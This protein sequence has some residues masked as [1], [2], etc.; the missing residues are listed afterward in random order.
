M[1]QFDH[2]LAKQENPVKIPLTRHLVEV[3]K[4]AE[5][6][7][8]HLE[9][10]PEIAYKGAIL[11]DIGKTSPIYQA[12]LKRDFRR[13]VNT[14]IFRHEIAS[15][16]F[17]SLVAEEIKPMVIDMIV[18]HHK[19][20][21]KD[22]RQL[23]ILDLEGEL[24]NNFELHAEGFDLWSKDA[25]GILEIFGFEKQVITID[26]AR[27]NYEFAVE[28]CSKPRLGCSLWKGLLTGSDYFA[29]GVSD[30]LDNNI[31]AIFRKPDLSF[32]NRINALYPLSKISTTNDKPHTLVTAPTGAGKTD[33]LIRRCKG[34]VFY[35]LPFQASI[36]AMYERIKEDLRETGADIR[37][38]HASSTLTLGKGKLEETILQKHIGASVKV[39]TPHQIASIVFGTKGYEAM[40]ADLKG[41]DIILDEIH[42]YSDITQAI[43]LK[44][45]E[46]LN[47]LNC[48][49]HIGTATMSTVLY[50]KILQIL[51]DTERVYEVKLQ[52]ETLDT[53]DRHIVHKTTS[54]DELYSVIEDAIAN[55]Q[56]IL[57]VCNQVKRAQT[58]FKELSGK[59]C[60]IDKMLI[61]SRFKRLDRNRLE[62]ELKNVYN[63]STKACF[64]VS[65][66]VVEVSLDISFDL[67]IT[68]CAPL[69]ALIQR[70]GRINRKR[71]EQTIGKYKPVYVMQPPEEKGD[72]LPYSLD[73]LKRSYEA[74]QDGKLNKERDLQ[75][76]LDI[77][78][79]EINF[80]DIDMNSVFN[81]GKWKIKELCHNPKSALLEILDIDSISCV[82]ESDKDD[83]I[84]GKYIERSK[85]EIPVSYHS[86]AHNGLEQ[87]QDRPKPFIIPDKAYNSELGFLI[88]F[89]RPEFYDITKRFL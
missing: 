57:I 39:L 42:T 40:V 3:A 1:N 74:L 51:G 7:A 50:G 76:L 9:V 24:D 37:L 12:T 25:L 19:S 66:Q 75:I 59:Y 65:T 58:L 13:T 8:A 15:L 85:L 62:T 23:G 29:S 34:R 63:N 78:Y 89:A 22:I 56:K 21:Y 55:N 26:E 35:T 60:N 79:P 69:D 41:C 67:M 70:F 82:C 73:V 43:V 4:V 77:V 46:V 64:V 32:Y 44:I 71:T 86:V 14:R 49:I 88:E 80:L 33:F 84:Q 10:S 30:Y 68:E 48:R 54:F 20:I 45:V 36:N 5:K 2:I 61:H 27:A 52:P 17:I 18:A 31:E 72:A 6:I 11:H 81:N 16:F 83:Y 38:L 47:F 53:F 87:L 28:H